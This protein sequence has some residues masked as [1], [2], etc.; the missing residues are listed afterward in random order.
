[1]TSMTKGETSKHES[2]A[3]AK[4][5]HSASLRYRKVLHVVKRIAGKF[6]LFFGIIAFI[7]LLLS[8]TD[9]PYNAYHALAMTDHKP[10]KDPDFIVVLGGNGIPS[11]DGLIRTWYAA[12][13][14]EQ[15]EQA[16]VVIAIPGNV[17]DTT[18]QPWLMARELVRR[19]IDRS[20]IMFEA[21]GYNTHSQAV[22][23][24]RMLSSSGPSLL[25]ITSPEHMY[26]SIRTFEKAGFKDASGYASFETPLEENSIKRKG[27]EGGQQVQNLDLRYNM[28][29]Y[30][31]YEI[32]VLREYAAIGY[33]KLQGWI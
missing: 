16:K 12:E 4:R 31:Q 14:A 15:F 22:N 32:L 6:F 7:M 26:R 3:S 29:S 30:L 19:G 8:F 1:M 5:D 13:A 18:D 17:K 24:S 27:N 9:I 2:T 28:W 23:I 21:K 11:P 20:R 25:I 33:Y 10:V